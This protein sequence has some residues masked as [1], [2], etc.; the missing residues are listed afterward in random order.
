MGSYRQV[1][2]KHKQFEWLVS[3][4]DEPSMRHTDKN[5][6][7]KAPASQRGLENKAIQMKLELFA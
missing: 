7:K 2:T 3:I 6:H 4:A 5:M 1:F